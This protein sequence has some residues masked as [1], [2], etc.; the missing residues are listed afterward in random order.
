V[1]AVLLKSLPVKE[2]EQLAQFKWVVKSSVKLKLPDY[3][4]SSRTDEATGLEISTSFPQQTFEQFRA[5]QRTLTDLFAFAGLEQVNANV[6]GQAEVASGQVVSGGYFAG[7]GVQPVLGRAITADDDRSG[8]PAVAVISFRYWERR[9]GSNPAVIGK[10]INLNNAS[11]T[12]IGVTPREFAGVMGSGNAPGFNTQNLLL[13][14][15]DPRLSGYSG[16][17]LAQLYQRM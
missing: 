17:R 4:G 9:F 2:P 13:F 7:L 5:Q 8:A 6:D 16:D 12:I 1:D 3:D 14:R 10:Q 15:V 11:F